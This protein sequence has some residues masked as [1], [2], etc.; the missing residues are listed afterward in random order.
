MLDILFLAVEKVVADVGYVW[1][2]YY[3]VHV[4]GGCNNWVL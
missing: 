3:V 1:C 2:D 4:P